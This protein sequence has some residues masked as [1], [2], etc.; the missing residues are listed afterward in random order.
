MKKNLIASK[1]RP[2]DEMREDKI[3]KTA[4]KIE[5]P[6]TFLTRCVQLRT[7]LV[8]EKILLLLRWNGETTVPFFFSLLQPR[9]PPSSSLSF[10]CVRG[11]KRQQWGWDSKN[12]GKFRVSFIRGILVILGCPLHVWGIYFLLLISRF[13]FLNMSSHI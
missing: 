1:Q 6:K 2:M 12:W 9:N 13:F 7:R 8:K 3:E 5:T 4:N 10:S 11:N